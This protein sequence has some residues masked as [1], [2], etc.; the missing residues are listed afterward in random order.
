[1]YTFSV[2]KEKDQFWWGTIFGM[3]VM[4][5]VTVSVSR[6]MDND[7]ASRVQL[8]QDIISSYNMGVKDAL[9][10]NPASQELEHACLELWAN[11]QR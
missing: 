8:P 6:I 1:M 5:L 11:K 3:V 10:T 4:F 2:D 9:K 7:P